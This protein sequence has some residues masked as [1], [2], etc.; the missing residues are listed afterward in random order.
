MRICSATFIFLFFYTFIFSQKTI[1]LVSPGDKYEKKCAGCV[2]DLNNVADSASFGIASDDSLNYWFYIS[3]KKAFN[4]LFVKKFGL[5]ADIVL[6][7]QFSCERGGVKYDQRTIEK[8]K[9]MPAYW[10]KYLQSHAQYF[11]DSV[12]VP[13]GK[14]PAEIASESYELNMVLLNKKLSCQYIVDYNTTK[15]KKGSAEI[16]MF[17]DTTI[18]KTSLFDFDS[19][20]LF[21]NTL[22]SINF[23]LK[24]SVPVSKWDVAKLYDS[25][26]IEGYRID[27]AVVLVKNQVFDMKPDSAEKKA[28]AIDEF[29]AFVEERQNSKI[30]RRYASSVDWEGLNESVIGSTFE[31]LTDLS[32]DEILE[33]MGQDNLAYRMSEIFDRKYTAEVVFY[34]EEYGSL[35]KVGRDSLVLLFNQAVKAE[36][37]K[38]AKK[39]F[40]TALLRIKAKEFYPSF[41][42]DFNIP[43]TKQYL[44]LLVKGTAFSY[45]AENID[46]QQTYDYFVRL[47]ELAPK[48]R[49]V[50]YNLVSLTF[51]RWRTEPDSVSPKQLSADMKALS[52][53]NISSKLINKMFIN[54]YINMSDYYKKMK[55]YAAMEKAQK[56]VYSYFKKSLLTDVEMMN[57]SEFLIANDKEKWA[58]KLLY[59]YAKSSRA[60]ERLVFYFIDL[61]ITDA[62]MTNRSAYVALLKKAMEMNPDK[63]CN[64]FVAN[65]N[66]GV[67]FQL[68]AGKRLRSFD[69][70]MC[71]KNRE[72]EDE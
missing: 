53:F 66:G 64:L 71:S 61:T 72:N 10:G 29:W 46:Y 70:S 44:P 50:N 35:K 47:K 51:D 17:A 14:L 54:Y 13:L 36:N 43:F 24:D 21:D 31:F 58:M 15:Y 38:S 55:D 49:S 20:R 62:S 37:I 40:N 52:H 22:F 16:G 5:A 69:C 2:A 39:I 9:L 23:A 7:S 60:T 12:I 19:T 68:L 34:G 67:S 41:I 59:P 11:G 28:K 3:S 56:G 26:N 33:R 45:L 1:E 6:R 32:E 48:D 57:I 30:S 25:L 18:F 63:T 65:R 27:S 4:S 8:G 42:E